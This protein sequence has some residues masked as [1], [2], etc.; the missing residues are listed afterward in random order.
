M[1]D[2]YANFD[3]PD[4]VLE[5]DW[6]LTH[7]RS[8][9]GRPR[10]DFTLAGARRDRRRGGTGA[11]PRGVPRHSRWCSFST[12]ATTR[13]CAPSSSTPTPRH[14]ALRP[15]RAPRCWRSAR[16]TSRATT[17]SR[18]SRAVRASRC[19]P[20]P[21]RP[22]ARRTASWARWASTGDRSFV[23]DAEGMVRYAH[24]SL[25][26]PRSARP[27]NWSPPSRPPSPTYADWS[28]NFGGSGSML[29]ACAVCCA[30]VH[31]ADP[32]TSLTKS[33][34]SSKTHA[35]VRHQTLTD[36]LLDELTQIVDTPPLDEVLDRLS[37]R[38]RRNLGARSR[39]LAR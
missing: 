14:S 1:Q 22:S 15:S 23:I 27:P 16:R 39:R 7:G 4:E 21:T 24:R 35:A 10:P 5:P 18:A 25:V 26:G 38:P 17:S 9:V 2:V 30:H 13:R 3:I 33:S 28:L 29:C 8:A 36:Y 12:R 19:W 6:R 11:Q 32:G 31:G 37:A 20:T 34:P